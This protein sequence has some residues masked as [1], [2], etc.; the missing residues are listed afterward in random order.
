M[1]LSEGLLHLGFT[2]TL[3]NNRIA[4]HFLLITLTSFA[5][6]AVNTRAADMTA[7]GKEFVE[8]LAK[9]DFAAAT[10]RYDDT[11]KAALPEA[12]LRE[13]WQ[14]LQAQAGRFQKQVRT[15]TEKVQLYDAE[16]LLAASRAL[17]GVKLLVQGFKATVQSVAPG[18]FVYL[19]P[20]Y[21]PVSSTANFTSYTRHEFGRRQQE[22]L[23]S[24]FAEAASRG[25]KLMLSNSDT[26]Y[27]RKL[28]EGFRIV[29]VTA[30]R[31]VN[32]NPGK[33]GVVP[34]VLVLSY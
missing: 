15:R 16:Q 12:K 27:V 21:D 32:S 5:M 23:A 11:M 30:R 13:T 22:E 31:T 8:L 3:M 10:A 18:D 28:Y 20:P 26:P 9:E 19:D 4:S 6:F 7:A 2:T 17:E 25:V 24:V 34:E 1:E 14:T 29:S 33:R